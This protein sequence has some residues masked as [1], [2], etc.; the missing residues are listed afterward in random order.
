LKIRFA[1]YFYHE[2][3]LL[4]NVKLWRAAAAPSG[5]REIPLYFTGINCIL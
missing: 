2:L 3:P 5:M 4:I 1:L